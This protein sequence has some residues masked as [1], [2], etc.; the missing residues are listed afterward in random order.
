VKTSYNGFSAAERMRADRIMRAAIRAGLISPTMR[1]FCGL[2]PPAALM[3]HLEDYCK[4]LEPIVACVECHMRLH[5]RFRAPNRW[6]AHCLRIRTEPA[7]PYTSVIHYFGAT[8]AERADV[9]H[10]A[11]TPDQSRWWENLSFERDAAPMVGP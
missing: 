10:V 3:Y 9:E 4:P 7:T 5:S 1:C 11:L 2:T 8:R 6:R